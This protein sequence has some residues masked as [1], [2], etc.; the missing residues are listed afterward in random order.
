MIRIEDTDYVSSKE[1]VESVGVSR[2]TLWRW[3][4]E[5]KIPPGHRFRDGQVLFT[6]EE[7]QEISDFA[8]RVE[9]IDQPNRDQLR[10]FGAGN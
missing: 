8:N 2:Q 5:G 4:R 7:L 10:L 3:R 6:T 9:P 1:I